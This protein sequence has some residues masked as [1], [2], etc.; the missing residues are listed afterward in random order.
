MPFLSS[1]NSQPTALHKKLTKLAM[2]ITSIILFA[3]I[4]HFGCSEDEFYSSIKLINNPCGLQPMKN[5]YDAIYFSTIVQST[6]GYGD[7]SPKKNK[8]KIIV[9][10]QVMI[11]FI[12]L[13]L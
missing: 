1:T 13:L 8:A 7:I 3:S 11:S 12:I 4:Y 2:F 6:L 5:W 9:I 10:C